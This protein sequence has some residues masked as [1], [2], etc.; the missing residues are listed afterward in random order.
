MKLFKTNVFSIILISLFG[1]VFA[2][3]VAQFAD[4]N[5]SGTYKIYGASLN[6]I[7]NPGANVVLDLSQLS[8]VTMNITATF[9]SDCASTPYTA[10]FPTANICAIDKSWNY[11]ILNNDS[12]VKIGQ[13]NATSS[14]I[15][16]DP[17]VMMV[18][19]MH[20]LDTHVD[21]YKSNDDDGTVN[22]KYEAYGTLKTQ[23]GDFTNVFT[24][25]RGDYHEFWTSAPI[26][27]LAQWDASKNL[28][29][30]Y[31]KQTTSVSSIEKNSN[32]IYPTIVTDNLY[33]ANKYDVKNVHIINSLGQLVLTKSISTDRLDLSALSKGI[34]LVNVEIQ[35]E[36]LQSKI[37]KQ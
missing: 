37:V 35:G 19:P 26:R 10:N 9:T 31:D 28:F 15:Y 20:F 17:E 21:T 6:S 1:N 8:L 18:F 12:L 5:L 2:Q 13:Q 23:F 29:Y 25:N 34:Y 16:S 22:L 4:M 11:L 24:I 36:M 33:F 3:P 7:G 14:T 27:I 30:F 32:T